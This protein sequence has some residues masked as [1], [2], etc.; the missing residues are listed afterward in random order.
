MRAMS[1]VTRENS[2]DEPVVTQEL[3][4]NS[5]EL[6]ITALYYN[7]PLT[8]SI[9]SRNNQAEAFFKHWFKKLPIFTRVHDRKL[10]IL[11]ITAMLTSLPDQLASMPGLPEQLMQAALTLFEGMPQAL[12]ARKQKEDEFGADEDD[13][14]EDDEDEDDE[15]VVGDDD[16][17]YDET[18]E[19]AELLVRKQREFDAS[20]VATIARRATA[21]GEEEDED[22][23]DDEDEYE[24]EEGLFGAEQLF[25]TPLDKQDSYITFAG[26]IQ[27]L[28]NSHQKLFSLATGSL[29]QKGQQAL[30]AIV[31]KAQ[32]GGEALKPATNVT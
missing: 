15:P 30:H 18:N 5:L 16:D 12:V 24:D 7:A 2:R 10:C 23:D 11:A 25:E 29:D 19:Y 32:Q 31:E 14:D 20:M 28:Q 21:G 17:I 27:A 9:L 22:D 13:D 1:F 8:L 4:A 3:H 26:A 6:I